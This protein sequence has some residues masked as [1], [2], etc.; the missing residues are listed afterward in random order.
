MIAKWPVTEM[1][2]TKSKD[3]VGT[4]D[5]NIYCKDRKKHKSGGMAILVKHD[6]CSELACPV[7]DDNYEMIWIRAHASIDDNQ[8]IILGTI[9]H[10]PRPIYNI[11]SL[12]D[13]IDEDIHKLQSDRNNEEFI[14]AGDFN[15]L[16]LTKVADSTGLFPIVTTATRGNSCLDNVMVSCKLWHDVRVV[17]ATLNSDHSAILLSN[18]ENKDF[19]NHSKRKAVYNY[20]PHGYIA[21]N[22]FADFVK[23]K[24]INTNFDDKTD[25]EE[26][27]KRYDTFSDSIAYYLSCFFPTKM[28][29]I[30]SRDPP[31]SLQTLKLC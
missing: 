30:T 9:Y 5:Y 22:T 19:I 11:A 31:L 18:R 25:R 4:D 6:I 17:K 21:C 13:K 7:T 16:N 8:W 14:M 26:L 15:M 20:H 24:S 2:L 1:Y 29:T 28:I 3:L 23:G 10:P 27:E 12:I